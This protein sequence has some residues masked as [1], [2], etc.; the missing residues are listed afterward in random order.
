MSDKSGLN[1]DVT[2]VIL[3]GIAAMVVILLLVWVWKFGQGRVRQK[4]ASDA[5]G[6][7]MDVRY[8]SV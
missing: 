6:Q 4:M 2:N 1:F 7:H 3:T 5:S 8:I